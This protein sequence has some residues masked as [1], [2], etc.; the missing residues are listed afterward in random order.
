MSSTRLLDVRLKLEWA[1]RHTDALKADIQRWC[2]AQRERLT[3]WTL[4]PKIDV[5]RQCVVISLGSVE[6]PAN[7]MLMI[8]DVVYNFRACLNYLAS[9]LVRVGRKPKPLRPRNVEFPIY[10]DRDEFHRGVKIRLPGVLTKH[11]AV[12]KRYQP[13][14]V[15]SHTSLVPGPAA[16]SGPAS[17]PLAVLQTLSNNDK[18]HNPQY[19][20]PQN[21]GQLTFGIEGIDFVSERLEPAD[22][23]PAVFYTGAEVATS[24]GRVTGPNPGVKMNL[25]GSVA[26]AIQACGSGTRSTRLERPRRNS[27]ARSS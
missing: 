16:I 3:A 1:K 6:L 2:D 14:R 22:P 11:R 21:Y 17:H 5:N 4:T 19:T 25:Q 13:Y 24:Y 18:H 12:V 10:A 8:G 23:F 26:I 20:F 15:P 7:W 9:D 27:L